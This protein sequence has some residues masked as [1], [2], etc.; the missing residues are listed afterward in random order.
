MEIKK[1]TK[2][3]AVTPAVTTQGPVDY[4][5]KKPIS[6]FPKTFPKVEEQ[7]VLTPLK[8]TQMAQTSV[9][10]PVDCYKPTLDIKRFSDQLDTWITTLQTLPSAGEKFEFFYDCTAAL[11]IPEWKKGDVWSTIPPQEVQGILDK[12]K[13]LSQLGLGGSNITS[14][15]GNNNNH[16]FIDQFL[17]IHTLY[18]IADKLARNCKRTKLDGFAS[19]FVPLHSR[20]TPSNFAALPL[21]ADHCRF[22]K[23]SKYFDASHEEAKGAVIFP[24][25]PILPVEQWA[26]DA[27]HFGSHSQGKSHIEFLRQHLFARYP[28]SSN[29]QLPPLYLHMWENM[30]TETYLGGESPL[31]FCLSCRNPF[32]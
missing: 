5:Q 9:I 20:Y 32:F 21:G 12:M 30:D 14:G 29:A 25:E 27:T 4:Q 7:H 28:Q 6:T 31:F 13:T 2:S 3:A 11:P 24:V 10:K 8:P 23:I 1:V 17:A 26:Y 16:L 18:I 22:A 15:V 19:P